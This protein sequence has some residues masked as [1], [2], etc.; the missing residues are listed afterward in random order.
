MEINPLLL[1]LYL[2]QPTIPHLLPRLH[3]IHCCTSH[4]AS[5][6]RTS[7]PQIYHLSRNLSRYQCKMWYW[8][9]RTDC[10]GLRSKIT[11]P[12]WYRHYELNCWWIVCSTGISCI[13]LHARR[14]L[15]SDWLRTQLVCSWGWLGCAS[16]LRYSW[17]WLRHR[18]IAAFIRRTRLFWKVT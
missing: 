12:K 11:R 1:H 9:S 16:G 7:N 6:R 8:D 14:K 3:S 18:L 17:M 2:H 4:L 15:G 5:N 13:P 10:Q